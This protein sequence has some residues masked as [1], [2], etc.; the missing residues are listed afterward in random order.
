MPDDARVAPGSCDRTT[1]L[2]NF[3]PPP[4]R[5]FVP[6]M[7]DWMIGGPNAGEIEEAIIRTLSWP[8][9][10]LFDGAFVLNLPQYAPT[11]TPI[12]LPT[13]ARPSTVAAGVTVGN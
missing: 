5:Y 9:E 10:T 4:K 3:S 2:F 12:T 13:A 1:D 6:P 11:G 8:P 7:Q